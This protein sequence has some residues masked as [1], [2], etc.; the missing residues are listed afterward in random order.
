MP[1]GGLRPNAPQNQFGVS[2]TGGNGS[3]KGQ[4]K[5]QPIRPLTGGAYGSNKASVE[6]ESAAPMFSS[7]SPPNLGQAPAIPLPTVDPLHGDGGASGDPITHGT[8]FGRGAGSEV[9]PQGFSGDNRSIEN[10]DIV[11]KYM[12]ALVQAM[13][14]RDATDSFKRFVNTLLKEVQNGPIGSNVSSG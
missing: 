5:S 11:Q 13:Q 10:V 12:P 2:A 14:A 8:D 7:P 6:Q 9:L 4:P 3:A 1:K